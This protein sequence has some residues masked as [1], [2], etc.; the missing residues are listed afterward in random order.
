MV[1]TRT[2]VEVNFASVTVQKSPPVRY[3][4]IS[5]VIVFAAFGVSYSRSVA[6][7]VDAMQRDLEIVLPG[8][9]AGQRLDLAA[10]M[11]MLHVGAVDIALI[12]RGRIARSRHFGQAASNTIYQAA[13]LSKLVTAIAALRLV[14][15]GTLDLDRNVNDDLIE[16]RIPDSDLTRGHP[17]TLRGLLSMTAGI[18]VPG[19]LGYAPG[20]P[21]PN[22]KQILDGKPPANS[23]PVRVEAIPGSRYAYSGGGYEIVQALIEAKTKQRFQDAIKTL[24]FGPVGMTNSFFLQPLPADLAAR[25]A[26]GHRSDGEELPGGWRVVPEL[27]AGGLWSSAS[28]LAALLVALAHSYRGEPNAV[29]SAPMAHLMMQRQNNGPYGLGGA[30]AGSGRSLVLM[31]RGQNIG[32]QSYMLLLPET[33]Q[34]IAILSNSDNGTTLATALIR[35]AAEIYYWPTI[36]MLAD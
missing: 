33:G 13:S 2:C 7:P 25:A 20:E 30:V 18:G 17:V 36:G 23:P 14:E 31:K 6:Q 12:E 35:R 29:L 8:A 34:G 28:D 27:A 4:A 16:W 9:A 22:L 32:Y 3:L 11:G 21:L 1:R 5:L 24:L 26:K 10:A 15:R 19:Y